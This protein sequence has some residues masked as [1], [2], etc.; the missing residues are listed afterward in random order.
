M[1]SWPLNS[2]EEFTRVQQ[3]TKIWS[4]AGSWVFLPT[5]MGPSG[6]GIAARGQFDC[7]G[8]LSASAGVPAR[9]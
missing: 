5:A 3:K 1:S 4:P 2:A 8:T 7:G 6:D 9:C